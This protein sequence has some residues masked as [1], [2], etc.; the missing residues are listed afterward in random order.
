[1]TVIQ[2][3]VANPAGTPISGTQVTI[4]LYAPSGAFITGTNTEVAQTLSLT[5]GVSGQWSADLTPNSAIGDGT[6]SY[7]TVNESAIGRVTSFIVPAQGGPL[8]LSQVKIPTPPGTPTGPIIAHTHS[9]SDVINLVPDLAAKFASGSIGVANGAASLDANGHVP[10]AQLPDLSGTYVK[11]TQIGGPNGVAQLD[12]NGLLPVAEVPSIPES[13]VTNLTSDLSGKVGTSQVGAANGVASL[14]ATTHVPAGQIPDLSATYVTNTKV[15]ANS[16]VASLDSS[17]DLPV[18][19]TYQQMVPVTNRSHFNGNGGAAASALPATWLRYA[20]TLRRVT[21]GGATQLGVEWANIFTNNTTGS[22][23]VN[24]PNSVSIR[25][26]VEYPAGNW[27]Q[28]SGSTAWASGTVYNPLDQVTYTDGNSYVAITTTTAGTAPTGALGTQWQQV[29]RYLVRWDNDDGAGTLAVAPGGIVQSQKINLPGP[30]PVGASMAVNMTVNTG[31]ATG[32]FPYG[33]QAQTSGNYLDWVQDWTSSPPAPGSASDPVTNWVTTAANAATSSTYIPAPSVVTGNSPERRTLWIMGDSIAMGTGDSVVD[34]EQPGW[35]VRAL[36]GAPYWRC[37]QGGQQMGTFSTVGATPWQMAA[38]GRCTAAIV[39]LG[40]NDLQ[41]AQ[42]AATIEA[43]AK[44]VWGE[45]AKRGLRVWATTLGPFTNSTDNWATLANQTAW[46]T[47][48]AG[49]F[50]ASSQWTIYNAW[51]MDGAPLTIEGNT[52]R[53]GDVRHPLAGVIS[54]PRAI[55]DPATGWKWIVNGA[56]NGYTIDGAHPSPLGHTT[57]A[58]RAATMMGAV[59]GQSLDRSPATGLTYPAV[60]HD[61]ALYGDVLSTTERRTVGSTYTNLNSNLV[62]TGGVATRT[63]TVTQATLGFINGTAGGTPT[64]TAA[65]YVGNDPAALAQAATIPVT[66]TTLTG[67]APYVST[68]ALSVPVTIQAG[69]RWYVVLQ[70]SG[71]TTAPGYFCSPGT[72]GST[73]VNFYSTVVSPDPGR[74]YA[75]AKAGTSLPATLNTADGSWSA[76]AQQ[77]WIVLT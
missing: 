62:L 64:Q 8:W 40:V 28:V 60:G 18:G 37:A 47:G 6:S 2:N 20:R 27:R 51:I 49:Q 39:Q 61:Y 55:I 14:D 56:A 68:L 7:Y 58:T 45:L 11:T 12:I 44:T 69:A 36:Q 38:A 72:A 13:R 24:G 1:M 52:V 23:E 63:V 71:Y 15:G 66:T 70:V 30:L 76:I 50:G 26:S 59:A 34:G 16:G 67:G 21:R 10:F 32:Q 48:G 43:R 9:E 33:F 57:I 29:G 73:A 74:I 3:T 35:I 25:M 54:P 77:P 4:N 31:S 22:T 65:L 53:A 42:T 75:A 17:G 19:Q 46:T 41:Q 5:T